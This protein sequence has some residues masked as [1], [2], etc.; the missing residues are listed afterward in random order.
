MYSMA[1]SPRKKLLQIEVAPDLDKAIRSSA[2][3]VGLKIA[4]YCRMLI[5]TAIGFVPKKKV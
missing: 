5:A 2:K 3:K 4:P 1:R